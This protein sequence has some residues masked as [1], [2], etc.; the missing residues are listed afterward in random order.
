MLL[1]FSF[2][3]VNSQWFVTIYHYNFNFFNKKVLRDYKRRTAR[4][5]AACDW[6]LYSYPT[7]TL[8][9]AL[10]GEGGCTVTLLSGGSRGGAP[11]C[12]PP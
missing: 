3:I 2:L 6:G 7:C 8:G 4:L 9:S 1:I 11:T 12:A 5:R 10:S